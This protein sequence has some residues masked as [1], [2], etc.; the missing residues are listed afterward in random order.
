MSISFYNKHIL[1]VLTATA[2]IALSLTTSCQDDSV[3]PDP[4]TPLTPNAAE[5]DISPSDST[6]ADLFEGLTLATPL[7]PY[8]NRNP[9]MTQAFGADPYAITYNDRVYIYMSADTPRLE[10]GVIQKNDYGNINRL[11]LL[12]SSD[13]AN[14]TEHPPIRVAGTGG[15]ARWATQSWAPAVAYKNIGGQT[16]FFL[17]F[18]NNIRGIGVLQ[19]DS[20]TGPF[21]DPLGRA[22]INNQTQG[23]AGVTWLFDPDVLVDDDGKAYIYFGGGIPGEDAPDFAAQLAALNTNHPMPGTIRVAELGND[24]TSI[25]SGS[26]RPFPVPFSFEAAAIDKIGGVYYFSYCTNF[27]VRRFSARP[28]QFPEAAQLVDGGTIAYM[29][30]D[31]PTEG[32]TLRNVI[33]RNPINMFGGRLGNNHHKMFEFKGGWYMA[34]HSRLL[35]V[36]M[37]LDDAGRPSSEDLGGYR[38]THV[39]A[40]TVNTATRTINRVDGTRTGVPQVGRFNPYDTISAA[41]IG[42]MAG[43]STAEYGTGANARM[44]V[45]DIH[46][47]DWVALHGADFGIIGAGKFT[48]RVTP[49]ASGFGAIQIRRGGLTGTPVG[50]VRVEPGQAE[51]SVDL[52]QTV[53]GVHDVVFVF[54]GTGW[55]FETWRFVEADE[56]MSVKEVDR[57][58]R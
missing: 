42:V 57:V 31:S 12:S 55:D 6:L 43:I 29:T 54:Y 52:M 16:R 9:I 50:Y 35:A 38:I 26:V 34:Y 13:L 19:S 39:D 45:T 46:S 36:A 20:P 5:T 18:S 10:G 49:P 2:I 7:K 24:M 32:F 15:I 40:V 30:S 11:R 48:C 21:T 37:G 14:W 23:V 33:L 51:Y 22:L 41:T 53:S 44:K 4:L 47:G 28:Q 25:V 58:V 3:L 27:E 8:G 56:S 17:Y 1:S